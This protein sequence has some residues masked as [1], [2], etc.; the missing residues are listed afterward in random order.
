MQAERDMT[1]C[2]S[3]GL[4]LAQHLLQRHTQYGLTVRWVFDGALCTGRGVIDIR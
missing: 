2:Q 3:R 1:L 4:G